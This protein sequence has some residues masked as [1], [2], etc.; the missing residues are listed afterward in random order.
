MEQRLLLECRNIQIALFLMLATYYVFNIE[1]CAKVKDVL[2]YIRERVLCFPDQSVKQSSVYRN[3]SA[4]IELYLPW[5]FVHLSFHSV[6]FTRL[7]LKL[8]MM[9]VDC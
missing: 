1:Y 2:Y 6:K 5:L 9:K 8:I 3:V 7:F 4:A